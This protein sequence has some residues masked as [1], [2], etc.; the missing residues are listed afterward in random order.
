M[1]ALSMSNDG[2][3]ISLK[4]LLWLVVICLVCWAG[5]SFLTQVGIHAILRH[6]AAASMVSGM[7]GPDGKCDRGPSAEL[8]NEITGR[9]TYICFDKKGE[10]DRGHFWILS[11]RINTINTEITAI[12][13]VRNPANYISNLFTRGNV[14]VSYTDGV[15]RWFLILWE[16]YERICR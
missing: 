4:F 10:K 8:Y 1:A 2:D 15:P 6:G 9:W 13:N 5:Y 14:L 16:F 11:D 3:G 7:F 12:P